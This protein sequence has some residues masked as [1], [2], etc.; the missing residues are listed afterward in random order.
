VAMGR[1]VIDDCGAAV[2]NPGQGL[3]GVTAQGFCRTVLG[4]GQDVQFKVFGAYALPWALQASAN[5]QVTPG[6][7]ITAQYVLTNADLAK[8]LGRAT[9]TS[10]ATLD[11]IQPDTM[12]EKRT[13]LLDLRFSRKFKIGRT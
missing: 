3:V 12:F 9:S 11:L 7:A 13:N 10:T 1:T 6:P 2:D 8:A 5:L 4:W